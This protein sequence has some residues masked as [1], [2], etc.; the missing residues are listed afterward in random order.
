MVAYIGITIGDVVSGLLSQ[1]LKSRKKVLALF[2]SITLVFSVLYYLFATTSITVF[3]IF[4]FMIG[5]GTGYWAVFM[6][7][8]SELFGT[9]IRATVT[10][11]APNFVRGSVTL[12]TIINATLKPSYGLVVSSIYIGIGVFIMA[13]LANYYLEETFHKDLNYSEE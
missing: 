5:F 3:Y 4:I 7:A 10:T 1:K 13:Y 2:I 8:A 6:S 12:M 11:T 9:N